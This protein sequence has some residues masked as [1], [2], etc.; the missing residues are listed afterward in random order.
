MELDQI[1]TGDCIAGMQGLPEGAI[2]LCFADPPFN[3][4]YEYAESDFSDDRPHHEYLDWS[5]SWLMEVYRVLSSTGTFWLMI[6][7]AYVSEL[8]VTAKT[9]GFYKRGHIIN[10]FTFGQNS[11]KKFTP[12]HVH[13]LY[14]VKHRDKFTFNADQLKVPSARQL[15]YNDK[16]AKDGGRCPDDVWI[17]R[18]QWYPEGFQAEMDTWH[19]P[20]IAGTFKQRAG[21]PNQ[22]PE[23]ILG[24]IIRGCSNPGE[25]VFD[26]FTGSGGT[27]AVAKKLG[28]HYFGFELSETYAGLARR[29]LAGVKLDDPLQGEIPQG[30]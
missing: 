27:P 10:H 9:L 29:R 7:D 14:Y 17:L 1:I 25:T 21:T 22:V 15:V 6:G 19:V 26:P 18:P 23:H 8:D 28:R 4:G 13:L 20:R 24:R 16:R 12:S 3:I 11:P 30:G 5:R 2:P